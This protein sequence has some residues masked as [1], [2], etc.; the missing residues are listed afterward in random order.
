MKAI[1]E[2]EYIAE[3]VKLADSC[4]AEHQILYRDSNKVTVGKPGRS[5]YRCDLILSGAYLIMVGDC[6]TMVFAYYSGKTVDGAIEWMARSDVSYYVRQKANI[7]MNNVACD[8]FDAEVALWEARDFLRDAIENDCRTV[9]SWRK[10][11]EA[12]EDEDREEWQEN[13]LA[14]FMYRTFADPDFCEIGLVPS[15]RLMW[16][17]SIV[18]TAHRLLE[19]AGPQPCPVCNGTGF[20]SNTW[21]PHCCVPCEGTGRQL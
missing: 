12:L 18:R 3:H 8:D 16:A 9:D 13:E 10:V 17:W 19:A 1:S 14:D 2:K 11:V 5:E 21:N 7:G 4:L 6:D 20:D 15:H